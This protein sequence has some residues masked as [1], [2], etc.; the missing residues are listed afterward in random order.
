MPWGRAKKTGL[1]TVLVC[2]SGTAGANFYPAV[3]EAKQSGI[4]LIIL[5]ADRPAELRNCHAGQTIDQVKL[6]G[7]FPNW[8]C[9]LALPEPRLSMLRYL[10]QTISSSLAKIVISLARSR[11]SQFTPTQ[12]P[13]THSTA[14]RTENLTQIF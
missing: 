1:P 4:P 3:I 7:H 11:P 13:R 6:Y 14:S 12:T 5:T 9:E 8:Q 2:T 10:R